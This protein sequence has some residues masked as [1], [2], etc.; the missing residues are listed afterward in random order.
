[1]AIKR[2]AVEFGIGTDL[3][4]TDYTKA[5]CRALRDALWH[6][7]LTIYRA[8]GYAPEDMLVEVVIGVTEPEKVDHDALKKILP[9]GTA[10]ITVNKGGLDIPHQDGSDNTIVANAAAIVSL[11]FDE[12]NKESGNVA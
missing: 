6:N 7:S 4:G 1:M 11:N 5:A 10:T 8:L 9:Y 2:I 12:V 3:R